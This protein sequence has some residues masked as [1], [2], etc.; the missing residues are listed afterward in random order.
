[1]E[2]FRKYNPNPKKRNVGDCVIRALS[3]ALNKDWFRTYLGIVLQGFVMCDM[4]SANYVWGAYL[5]KNGFERRMPNV[6]DPESYTVSDFCDDHPR[7]TFVLALSGH[8]VCAQ[9]GFFYDTWDSG[10]EIV[11]YFWQK[12]ERE[13]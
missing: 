6:R 9:N 12:E 3:K 5:K 1:M 8:V 4:P 11:I 13:G 10:N 7:G 2:N